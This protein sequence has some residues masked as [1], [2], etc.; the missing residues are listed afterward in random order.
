M[1]NSQ[2]RIPLPQNVA[3]RSL[4]STLVAGFCLLP[5]VC[6]RAVA[7]APEGLHVGPVYSSSDGKNFPAFPTLEIVVT[8]PAGD[9]ATPSPAALTLIEDG[10]EGAAAT[11]VS[12]FENKGYGLAAAVAVD[13]SGSMAGRPLAIIRESLYKFASEARSQ[14]SVGVMTIADDAQWDVP[15]GADRDTLKARLQAMHTRGTMTRLYDG[16]ITALGRF[17][18]SLPVRRE[19]TVITDGHDEGSRAHLQ[20][21]VQLAREHGIAIDAV[22]LTRSSPA[23]LGSLREL[24]AQTGGSFHQV[25]NDP[26]LEKLISGG[27]ARLKA[28]PV[29]TFEAKHIP[30]DGKQHRL[31]VRWKT[32]SEWSGETAFQAPELSSTQVLRSIKRLPLWVYGLTAAG[33][34]ALVAGA[35][36][37]MRR[38][39]R[40]KAALHASDDGSYGSAALVNIPPADVSWAIANRRPPRTGSGM[41]FEGVSPVDQPDAKQA[42]PLLAASAAARPTQRNRTRIAGVFQSADGT[43]AR[44][45]VLT[46]PLSGQTIKVSCGQFWIGAAPGNQLILP[47]DATVSSRHAYLL[48]EDPILLIVD[49]QSTNG[50]RI[51]GQLIGDSRRPVHDGDQI[52]IGQTLMRLKSMT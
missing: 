5:L 32:T 9:Q 49:N 40:Q 29:G 51:G 44:L 52:Q 50:T 12:S 24:A 6:A 33:S 48:F 20:D 39:G 42:E 28:T 3:H 16:L 17:D 25:H 46:G 10:V 19:L 41:S 14:D 18:A 15:F 47:E 11:E 2:F 13:V 38:R 36:Y 30:A 22:G 37:L 43:I 45:E 26:E 7:P 21:V 34:I 23:Y 8:P 27:M 1:T 4:R 31:G 35:I